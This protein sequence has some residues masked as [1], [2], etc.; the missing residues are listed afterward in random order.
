VITKT[1]VAPA[2]IKVAISAT[3]F[4]SFDVLNSP[5]I[6]SVSTHQA[7]ITPS[8]G[9]ATTPLITAAKRVQ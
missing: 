3:K 2:I 4:H 1:P 5:M 8:T 7:T 6:F 9:T